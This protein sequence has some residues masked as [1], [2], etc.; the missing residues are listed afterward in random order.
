MVLENKGKA[1]ETKSALDQELVFKASM[2][3]NKEV[4]LRVGQDILALEGN[5][6]DL[7]IE[8]AID[9]DF[10]E[11]GDEDVFRFF[12]NEITSRNISFDEKAI[13]KMMDDEFQK[14]YR[15]WRDCNISIAR[16][17]SISGETHHTC[18]RLWSGWWYRF[19]CS[20]SC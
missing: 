6:L 8:K 5:D 9:S 7:F 3:R 4:G 2:K 15:C 10:E 16:I 12:Q 18:C 17:R 11:K 19:L 13:R 20:R 14:A 1:E